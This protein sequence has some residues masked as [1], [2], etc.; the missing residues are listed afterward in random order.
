MLESA[1]Y[2]R[3]L[4]NLRIRKWSTVATL[5][6]LLYEH[7]ITLKHEI[8]H[9]WRRPFTMVRAT[10]LFSRYFGIITQSIT[11]YLILSPHLNVIPISEGICKAW[12]AFG[13]ASSATLVAAL[14]FILMLIIYALYRKDWRIGLFLAI[15]FFSHIAVE[16]FVAQKAVEVTYDPICDAMQAPSELIYLCISIWIIHISLGILTGI[17]YNLVALGAPVVKRLIRDGAWVIALICS[18]FTTIVPYNMNQQVAQG[19]VIFGWP[20]ALISIACCRVIMNMQ[21]LDY[22]E[23]DDE[24]ITSFNVDDSLDTLSLETQLSEERIQEG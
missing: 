18:F 5:A 23:A 10:Y 1:L 3:L 14:D 16:V 15:L 11:T 2:G 4:E 17:K 12:F 22:V 19:H 20:N 9:I 13:V 7:S 24:S 8:R 6:I 21:T